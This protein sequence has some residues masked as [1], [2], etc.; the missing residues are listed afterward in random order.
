MIKTV[1]A[2]VTFLLTALIAPNGTDAAELKFLCGFALASAMTELVPEFQRATGHIVTASYANVG[3]ITNRVRQGEMAD[4]AVVSPEQSRDLEKEGKIVEALLVPVAKV[5][6]GLAVKKG[7]GKPDLS[8]VDAFKHA[9]LNARSIAMADPSRGSPVSAYLLGLF[10]RLGIGSEL[11][12]KTILTPSNVETFEALASGNV[13]IAT[14]QV[15]EI[16]ASPYADLVGPLP[17]EIQNFT[18][19]T[20]IIPKSATAG[21]AARAF[22]EFLTSSHAGS[23]YKSKG[24]EPA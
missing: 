14:S 18:V 4:V 20:A 7:A 9:L 6:V 1:I 12:R 3:V 2:V 17:S 19:L 24:M 8:T 13:D 22:I 10:D 15:S 16:V 11:R 5:G 23:I 21:G